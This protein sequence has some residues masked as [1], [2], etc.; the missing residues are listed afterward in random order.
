M[1][2]FYLLAVLL[3]SPAAGPPCYRQDQASQFPHPHPLPPLCWQNTVPSHVPVLVPL[4]GKGSCRPGAGE[5]TRLLF[6]RT[7]RCCPLLTL[8]A[9]EIVLRF[10]NSRNLSLE[11]C[12]LGQ[13]ASTDLCVC[14]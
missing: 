1:I 14:V 9:L 10:G 8:M 12:V 3:P 6:L 11:A 7:R 13:P 2:V 4:F 5:E